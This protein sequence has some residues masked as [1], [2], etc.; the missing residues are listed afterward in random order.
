M[1]SGVDPQL[2]GPLG[3]HQE[4][5]IAPVVHPRGVPGGDAPRLAG[6][7]A[8]VAE[9]RRQLGQPFDG[10]LRPRPF[11]LA[12]D[13]GLLPLPDLDGEDLVVQAAR[14]HRL[15]GGKLGMERPL[16]LLRAAETEFVRHL[17]AVERHVAVVEGAPEAVVDHQVHGRARGE[18][19]L[20][21]PAHLRQAEGGV[22][23]A[24]LAAGDADLRP[25]ELD[26]LDREI[27]RLDP[28][29]ADLVHGDAGDRFGKTRQDRRLAAGDLAAPGGDDLPHEDVVHIGRLD[30][31]VRPAE[32]LLDGQ[33][34]E[35]RGGESLERPAE[36]AVGR[37][38]GLDEDD[39]PKLRGRFLLPGHRAEKSGFRWPYSAT[40]AFAYLSQASDPVSGVSFPFYSPILSPN[41]I[42]RGTL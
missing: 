37:P 19:H 36:A 32:D 9:D 42:S 5:D 40:G 20:G 33:G 10:R 22:G 38:A 35:F 30:L 28:G 25:A 17:R 12:Q 34:A 27:D 31:P 11:I 7:R 8:L 15:D 41:S 23:H 24:L 26:H 13:G 6:D 39:L 18:A 14:L 4:A 2:G 16:V 1:Q 29:G 3:A 21:A